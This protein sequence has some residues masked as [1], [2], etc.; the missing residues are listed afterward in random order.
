MLIMMVN[1][2]H[3]HAKKCKCYDNICEFMFFNE[4]YV[5]LLSYVRINAYN[6]AVIILS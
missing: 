4:C 3:L 1:G 2:E 5:R 6:C